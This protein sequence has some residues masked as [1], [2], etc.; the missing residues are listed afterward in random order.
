M[1][2]NMPLKER[3]LANFKSW[4]YHV[5]DIIQSCQFIEANCQFLER[6]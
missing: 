2:T 6:R 3:W 4:S 1:E 5:A